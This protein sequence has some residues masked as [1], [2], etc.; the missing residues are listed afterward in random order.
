MVQFLLEFDTRKFAVWEYDADARTILAGIA[1]VV[2]DK[3]AG[4]VRI[5]NSW[6]LE[7]SLNFYK[8]KDR[9][10]WLQP[11]VRAPVGPGADYY[12]LM[13][14]DRGATEALHLRTIYVGPNSGTILA[15]PAK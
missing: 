12:V 6:Q 13:N 14:A 10:D 15:A 1:K 4:S 7:P 2:P 5:A 9:L 3:R 11:I 8:M